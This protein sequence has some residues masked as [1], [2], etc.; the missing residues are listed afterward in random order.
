ML[1]I[2]DKKFERAGEK[3]EKCV[4][5]IDKGYP[6]Q[7]PWN[8]SA[9]EQF[10]L[11]RVWGTVD[12]ISK[13]MF[14]SWGGDE[15]LTNRENCYVGCFIYITPAGSQRW[16]AV[17]WVLVNQVSL[18]PAG[19]SQE[20][21]HGNGGWIL[22]L[23]SLD[24]VIF[25]RSQTSWLRTKGTNLHSRHWSQDCLKAKTKRMSFTFS[26]NCSHVWLPKVL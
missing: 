16:W 21:K 22:K 6:S 2:W 1:I 15:N 4:Y 13:F 11:S 26:W 23:S 17:D 25:D 10:M 19:L 24:G 14:I 3:K 9:Q 20:T 7:V 12:K 5:V 18:T 8:L